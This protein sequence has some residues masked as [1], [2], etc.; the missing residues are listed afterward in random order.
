M[1]RLPLPRFVVKVLFAVVQKC[2]EL[3]VAW[4]GIAC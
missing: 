2:R 4:G 3:E 1:Y